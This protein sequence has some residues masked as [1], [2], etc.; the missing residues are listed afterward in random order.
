VAH[1]RERRPR[2]AN[3]DVSRRAPRNRCTASRTSAFATS[4]ATTTSSTT[5]TLRFVD[6]GD[7]TVTDH[8][9][10]LTWE[11]K[12]DTCPGIHCVTDTYTWSTNYW[13]GVPDGTAFVTFLGT[14]NSCSIACVGTVDSCSTN[15]RKPGF[16]DHCDWRLPTIE[17]LQTILLA[18]PCGDGTKS[19]C[20]DPV[21][22]PTAELY[23]STTSLYAHPCPPLAAS[24]RW[25]P[26]GIACSSVHR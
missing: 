15:F 6:N 16:A 17:E 12:D 19:P 7:G 1:S 9:T 2:L 5:T 14:L 24:R 18:D 25:Y 26:G 20:I 21:F 4:T 10:G 8:Q 11:K 13:T 3:R 23:W 22:G